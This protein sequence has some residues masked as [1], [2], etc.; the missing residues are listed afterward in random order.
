MLWSIEGFKKIV[1]VQQ[2]NQLLILF[3][4]N[5]SALPFKILTTTEKTF[6][7]RKHGEAIPMR[8]STQNID[9]PDGFRSH[10]GGGGGV[11]TEQKQIL[12]GQDQTNFGRPGPDRTDLRPTQDQTKQTQDQ[13]S[14]RPT[15]PRPDQTDPQPRS[16]AKRYFLAT[17]SNYQMT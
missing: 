4:L 6:S 7:S 8:S 5:Y 15:N 16:I 2:L 14:A 17:W 11:Q 3:R 13:P 1:L 10:T 9:G 12:V